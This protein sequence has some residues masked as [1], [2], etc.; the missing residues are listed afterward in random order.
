MMIYT[1]LTKKALKLAYNAH[2]GDTDKAGTPYIFHPVAVAEIVL[3]IFY[4]KRSRADTLVSGGYYIGNTNYFE[5]DFV[6][7]LICVALLHD[8]LKDNNTKHS[9]QTLLSEMTEVVEYSMNTSELE[10]KGKDEIIRKVNDIIEAIKILTNEKNKEHYLDYI[11]DIYLSKNE[12]A[13]L[14]KIADLRHSMDTTRYGEERI[15]SEHQN[16]YKI[17]RRILGDA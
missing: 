5:S 12:L 1:P 13:I 2:K 14:V 10:Q 6:E 17:A 15:I 8:V 9:L 7:C 4:K 3:D 16:L 11:S